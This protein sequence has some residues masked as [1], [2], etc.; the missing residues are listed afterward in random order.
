MT[1]VELYNKT[2]KESQAKIRSIANADEKKI[3]YREM[4]TPW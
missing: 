1:I 3:N 4:K 2:Q